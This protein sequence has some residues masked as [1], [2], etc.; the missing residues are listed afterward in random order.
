MGVLAFAAPI[1]GRVGRLRQGLVN[2]LEAIF[3]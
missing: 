2:R 1:I 3:A